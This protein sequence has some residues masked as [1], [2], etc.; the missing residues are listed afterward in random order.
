MKRPPL[1]SSI[2]AACFAVWNG[3]WNPGRTAVINSS[4]DVTAASAAV[5]AHASSEGAST[6]LMSLRFS[7]GIS[8]RSNPPSSAARAISAMW[9]KDTGVCSSS[10]LRSQPPK[11]GVQ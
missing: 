2:V 4:D 8:V 6:P 11:M 9:A 7:S 10:T 3:L 1:I 5:T